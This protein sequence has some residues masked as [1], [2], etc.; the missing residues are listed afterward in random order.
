VKYYLLIENKDT[1]TERETMFRSMTALKRALKSADKALGIV[2]KVYEPLQNKNAFKFFD[3][4]MGGA[5][6]FYET[7]GALGLGERV[8]LLAKLPNCIVVK[9]NDIVEKY[10]LLTNNHDGS[11]SINILLTPIRV[12]CQNTLNIALGGAKNADIAK[13]RHCSTTQNK[14]EYVRETL[15]LISTKFNEFEA[16]AHKLSS[17]MVNREMVENMIKASMFTRKEA[18]EKLKTRAQNIIEDVLCIFEHGKGNDLP[19]T[20]HSV[21]TAFNSVVEYVDYER[22]SNP[23]RR[24]ESILFGSDQHIK[25]KAFDY[26]VNLIK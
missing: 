26:A 3:D 24:D 1:V 8:W 5:G 12:V 7:A 22:G 6:A 4:V 25:Q 9:G 19:E 14:I 21:W 16:I 10:L 13:I 17:K 2:G 20:K 11:T 23:A 15:G 18:T